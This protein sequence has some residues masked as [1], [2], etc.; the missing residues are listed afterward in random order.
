MVEPVNLNRY[1]KAKA[2]ADRKAQT[3]ENSVKFG[4]TKTES[5]L[6]KARADKAKTEIDQHKLDE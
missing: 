3:S 2:R 5:A 1:R 4:Q 6:E